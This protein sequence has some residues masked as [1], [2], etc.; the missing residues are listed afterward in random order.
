MT[1]S[2]KL[3]DCA[4]VAMAVGCVTLSQR[5]IVERG[6]PIDFETEFEDSPVATRARASAV[7]AGLY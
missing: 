2:A 7:C 5:R 3:M 1:C 6:M 4:G